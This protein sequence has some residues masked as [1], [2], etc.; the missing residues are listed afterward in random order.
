M[1][2]DT[3]AF[4][5]L[6]FTN[7]LASDSAPNFRVG[8]RQQVRNGKNA[9]RLVEDFGIEPDHIVRPHATDFLPNRTRSSIFDRIAQILR[10]ESER[11]QRTF[12]YCII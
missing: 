8:W 1:P 2:S 3:E 7:E 6:P 9:G 5:P 4:K 12:V 11:S 10:K